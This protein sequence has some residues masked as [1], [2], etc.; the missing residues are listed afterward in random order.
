MFQ[1]VGKMH[2]DQRTNRK[3]RDSFL[4]FH[5]STSHNHLFDGYNYKEVQYLAKNSTIQKLTTVIHDN[6]HTNAPAF[7]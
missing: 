5:S 3:H 2:I 1:F 7:A 6:T 4:A